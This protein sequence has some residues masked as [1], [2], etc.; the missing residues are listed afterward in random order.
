M[1]N[2]SVMRRANRESLIMAL[3]T[4]LSWTELSLLC[5]EGL[6]TIVPEFTE[7][8]GNRRRFY[9]HGT[10]VL[11]SKIAAKF[12]ASVIV[13]NRFTTLSFV[14]NVMTSGPSL[15]ISWKMYC[16]YRIWIEVID[17]ETRQRRLVL[18]KWPV[19]RRKPLSFH[20]TAAGISPTL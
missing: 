5:V 20:I 2:I 10:A 16:S 17:G 14:N 8:K 19:P 9:L 15:G 11:L 7:E 1:S 6:D 3:N 18:K 13:V 4:C 12:N